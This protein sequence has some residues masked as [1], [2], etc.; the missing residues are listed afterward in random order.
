M[1]ES[2]ESAED[3]RRSQATDMPVQ[4][5]LAQASQLLAAAG[6]D[7][8]DNDARL[9]LAEACQTN[10]HELDKA[11]LM[12]QTLGELAAGS[13]PRARAWLRLSWQVTWRLRV[14]KASSSAEFSGNLCNISW[15]TR[16]SAF[17]I[18]Q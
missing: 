17:S 12:R 9:L 2:A 18:W 16:P 4:T 15:A 8:P 14:L 13:M 5:V 1:V 10:L 7:T 11:L 6:I 3:S